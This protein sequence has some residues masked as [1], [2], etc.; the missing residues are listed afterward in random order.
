MISASTRVDTATRSASSVCASNGAEKGK[1]TNSRTENNPSGRA[2]RAI[3]KCVML[4]F[5]E[6]VLFHRRKIGGIHEDPLNARHDPSI[7][8]RFFSDAIPLGILAEI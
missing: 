3:R 1:T 8:L 2:T 4:V 6:T 5:W 7:P